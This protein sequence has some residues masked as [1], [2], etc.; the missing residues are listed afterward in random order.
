METL[1][2]PF[3][4]WSFFLDTRSLI[5]ALKVKLISLKFPH[6]L[7]GIFDIQLPFKKRNKQTNKQNN[8]YYN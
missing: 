8:D 2:L 7:S 5:K 6:K 3:L 1:H 4:F